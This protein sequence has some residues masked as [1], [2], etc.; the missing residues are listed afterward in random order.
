MTDNKLKPIPFKA[1]KQLFEAAGNNNVRYFLNGLLI[2]HENGALVATNGHMLAVVYDCVEK[3]GDKS[4]NRWLSR[5]K[6]KDLTGSITPAAKVVFKSSGVIEYTKKGNFGKHPEA[7][8]IKYDTYK[9]HNGVECTDSKAVDYAKAFPDYF[10]A[11]H[12]RTP[13]DEFSWLNPKYLYTWQ[14]IAEALGW[15]D[16]TPT[17]TPGGRTTGGP[18]DGHFGAATRLLLEGVFD[19]ELNTFDCYIMPVNSEPSMVP[20]EG[21]HLDV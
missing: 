12:V 15:V 7:L 21:G 16:C 8:S 14:Q 2:D 17:V 4:D 5:E 10:K 6:V 1:V 20:V 9:N 13:R 18:D 19:D 11:M 3:T